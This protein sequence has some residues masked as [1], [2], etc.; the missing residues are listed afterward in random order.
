M[1]LALVNC[2][3]ANSVCT[4]AACLQAM[5]ER[6]K[7]FECYKGQ[8]ITLCALMRCNGCGNTVEKDAGM[9]EKLERIISMKP[10]VAHFGKCTFE[11]DKMCDTMEDFRTRL[12]AAGI[13]TVLGTH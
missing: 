5:N 8:D 12:E 13:K 3:R 4:G 10:D 1:K 9:Q 2:G 6:S 7:N 11:K